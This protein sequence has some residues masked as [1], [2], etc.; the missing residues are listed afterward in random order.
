MLK[1]ISPLTEMLP[2]N[3]RDLGPKTEDFNPSTKVWTVYYTLNGVSPESPDEEIILNFYGWAPAVS[4]QSIAEAFLSRRDNVRV[5]Y[6]FQAPDESTKEPAYFVVSQ[7]NYAGRSYGF[8]NITKISS[9]AGGAYAATYSKKIRGSRSDE[10]VKDSPSVKWLSGEAGKA[11]AA[12][13]GRIG[14]EAEWRDYLAK[15]HAR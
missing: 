14:V 8:V 10:T 2:F 11:A 1:H 6:K 9:V 5:I 13:I 7:T 3:S 12:G 15:G 4:S